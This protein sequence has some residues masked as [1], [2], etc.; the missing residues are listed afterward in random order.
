MWAGGKAR[1]GGRTFKP[2]K[3][4]VVNITSEHRN[5]VVHSIGFVGLSSYVYPIAGVA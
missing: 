4:V 2:R 1:C 3:V 5:G